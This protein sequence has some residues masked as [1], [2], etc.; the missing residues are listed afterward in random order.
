MCGVAQVYK[1][2]G[3]CEVDGVNVDMGGIWLMNPGGTF[4]LVLT[5]TCVKR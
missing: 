1:V 3:V 2:D 5:G 4:T